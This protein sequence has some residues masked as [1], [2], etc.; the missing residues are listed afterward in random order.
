MSYIKQYSSNTISKHVQFTAN[1][2]TYLEIHLELREC[3]IDAHIQ[4][5]IHGL[6]IDQEN[7]PSQSQKIMQLN[8]LADQDAVIPNDARIL[9]Y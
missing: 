9:E 1:A 4:L 7:Y 8:I 5:S 3:R 2:L 6:F